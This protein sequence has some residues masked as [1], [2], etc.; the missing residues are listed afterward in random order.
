MSM[1][2]KYAMGK[3]AKKMADGGEA[4]VDPDKAK[5]AAESMRKAFGYAEGGQVHETLDYTEMKRGDSRKGNTGERKGQSRAGVEVREAKRQRGFGDSDS[6]GRAKRAEGRA[7]DEHKAVLRDLKGSRRD[8]TNLAE[9]GLVD[10]IMSKRSG[11]DVTADEQ[12]NEFDVLELDPAPS[13]PHSGDDYGDDLGNAELD[14]NDR[15]LISRI[16]RSRAKKDRMPR[17]A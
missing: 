3:K 11:G 16:M 8:R 12:P 13:P 2:I 9:G 10:R 5:K 7:K 6:D 17:P 1:A 14:E 4:V 15:D